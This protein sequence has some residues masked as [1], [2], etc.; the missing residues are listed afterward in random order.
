MKNL[1]NVIEIL[2]IIE[3]EI[4]DR[5]GILNEYE[6]I[7]KCWDFDEWYEWCITTL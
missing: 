5:D 6:N 1:K 7:V 3:T 2:S 4:N